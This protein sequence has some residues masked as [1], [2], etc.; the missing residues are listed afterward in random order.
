ME[1]RRRRW[2]RRTAR[3]AR[4]TRRSRDGGGEEMDGGKRGRAG[5]GGRVGG[6]D[7]DDEEGE[8]TRKGRTRGR[9][10]DEEAWKMRKYEEEEETRRMRKGRRRTNR[11]RRRRGD[12][13]EKGGGDM[14]DEEGEE[15]QGT[16]TLARTL[17]RHLL[18]STCTELD[19][20]N[21]YYPSKGAFVVIDV[22]DLSLWD[23]HIRRVNVGE[24]SEEAGEEEEEEEAAEDEI[25]EDDHLQYTEGKE[26]PEEGESEAG[27]DDPDY[28]ESEDAESEEASSGREE[29]EEE[30]GGS[31]ESSGPTELSKEEKEAVAQRR[32]A[33]TE[34]KRHRG[35]R[36]AATAI[37]AGRSDAQ[38]RAAT[39][40]DREKWRR[41]CRGIGKPT[42]PKKFDYIHPEQAFFMIKEQVQKPLESV[43]EYRS[44][45]YKLFVKSARDEKVG[46]GLFI[47]G[48]RSQAMRA[49]L[50]K[51]F[52]P[53]NHTMQQIMDGAEER[54]RKFAASFLEGEDHAKEGDSLEL[55]RAK[56][57]L[58]AL[59]NKFE[60]MGFVSSPVTYLEQV[61][62]VPILDAAKWAQWWHT[63]VALNFCLLEVIFHWAE[64]ADKSEEDEIPDDGVELFI[65]QAWRTD[66][67][68]ELLG[69]LFG[70]A[71]SDDP[72]YHE[73]EDAKSEEASPGLEESEEE[74]GGSGE[75][76]GPTELSR[77]EKEVVA[78]RRRAA[79]E[80]KRPI[81]ELEGPLP[82]LLQGDPVLNPELPQ[83]EIERN[84]GATTED[85]EADA[86]EESNEGDSGGDG[87]VSLC[88]TSG[89]WMSVSS[90][91]AAM[92]GD[93]SVSA[94]SLSSSSTSL[95]SESP[96]SSLSKATLLNAAQSLVESSRAAIAA[97]QSAV[98]E[99]GTP[100]DLA[101][102]RVLQITAAGLLDALS[103]LT[104]NATV[105]K[106]LS[107]N[108]KARTML[109]DVIT[110]SWQ[111][112]ELP[113]SQVH[114][115]AKA[116]YQSQ[117]AGK[118]LSQQVVSKAQNQVQIPVQVQNDSFVQNGGQL[119]TQ[120]PTTPSM[121][122]GKSQGTVQ[123]KE[124]ILNQEQHSALAASDR[125]STTHLQDTTKVVHDRGLRVGQSDG[126]A[127]RSS[128][129]TAAPVVQA[130]D[131]QTP[132]ANPTA[133]GKRSDGKETQ[134]AAAAGG[135]GG[136]TGGI[137]SK[138]QNQ[139]RVALCAA[140]Y[141]EVLHRCVPASS[142]SAAVSSGSNGETL[143]WRDG[144]PRS[145]DS[146]LVADS[147]GVE[148]NSVRPQSPLPKKP[149]QRF[150][151]Q[152]E[153]VH[154]IPPPCASAL[155]ALANVALASSSDMQ[156]P[157]PDYFGQTAISQIDA[158]KQRG[159]A[160]LSRADH[161]YARCWYDTSIRL[162]NATR[163]QPGL[164]YADQ[165]VLWSNRAEACI[166]GGLYEEAAR[167]AEQALALQPNHMKSTLRLERAQ[168]CLIRQRKQMAHGRSD[169]ASSSPQ[170]KASASSPHAK[171]GTSPCHSKT[172]QSE[173]DAHEQLAGQGCAMMK[174][175]AC[176]TAA[177]L[178]GSG[179]PSQP[180][181]SPR[182][183]SDK[184]P[185][186]AKSPL[187]VE[188][189]SPGDKSSK[190]KSATT[191]TKSSN[192]TL[193]FDADEKLLKTDTMTR[194]TLTA[195]SPCVN[196]ISSTT[197]RKNS[198]ASSTTPRK[199]SSASSTTPRKTATT[200]RKSL[201]VGKITTA[202]Q[203][204]S[205]VSEGSCDNSS[206]GSAD[207]PPSD[208]RPNHQPNTA[209]P[210]SIQA[211]ISSNLSF[212]ANGWKG[213]QVA[214][215]CTTAAGGAHA[216]TPGTA[217]RWNI[218]I[219][220]S[221]A[222]PRSPGSPESPNETAGNI[223]PSPQLRHRERRQGM[224]RKDNSYA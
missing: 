160:A 103:N 91:A 219:V 215:C 1:R 128:T 68:G 201:I 139:L 163:V 171:V 74:E 119:K 76:S 118:T 207:N 158:A 53:I 87:G 19:G 28:H 184:S 38:S 41:H 48:L 33:A 214:G 167:D 86:A 44:R 138:S 135:G 173:E 116:L 85:R 67:E 212:A 134:E 4:T 3:I 27:S 92:E 12:E 107:A 190:G 149:G 221:P 133:A 124:Q 188:Q 220:T 222:S 137:I 6:G 151:E 35:I 10:G 112:Q 205:L 114:A 197:P 178:Q 13:N 213:G 216:V 108:D 109:E 182:K 126:A 63:Y 46:R 66:M 9:E 59:R 117:A 150:S 82:Q 224:R 104:Y 80:S 102:I 51:Q 196:L 186:A 62:D 164:Q 40:G 113:R 180:E 187:A 143:V 49:K 121:R 144:F 90:T 57:E 54:E 142:S 166:R 175:A 185:F 32:R 110:L 56:T 84:G 136:G 165:H 65:I 130:E 217:R 198:S 122:Q 141:V 131:G 75:S 177:K 26:T 211:R 21:C 15:E 7:M 58:A 153:V 204:P 148:L 25:L 154:H 69:I 203:S 34:G 45:F 47:D 30:E 193:W 31:G 105:A 60:N 70:E 78:Q 159:N 189:Q 23:P 181:K 14:E 152:R 73:L 140:D 176:A 83:E 16:A 145:P 71:G 42:P 89:G 218:T 93:G 81:E 129:A 120:S 17:V 170:S 55:A 72:D 95:L 2:T 179:S 115:E 192:E 8:D 127:E 20:D 162:A 88:S 208:E 24:T 79:M 194:A 64:P 97:L 111:L 146:L 200:P 168:E 77:E 223:T 209:P 101:K 36:G 183:S 99:K 161:S 52:S 169:D 125:P 210:N 174:G 18:W 155:I 132:G 61:L 157:L 156:V 199:N 22:T 100:R 11:R 206:S 172:V 202:R 195:G 5:G 37:A 106:K 29:S 43:T 98:H 96:S 94:S 191:T 39:G 123:T 147:F 50:R